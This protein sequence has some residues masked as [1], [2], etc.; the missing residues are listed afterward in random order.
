MQVRAVYAHVWCVRVTAC[1]VCVVCDSACVHLKC[2]DM[3]LHATRGSAWALA[4]MQS[5]TPRPKGWPG[6][7]HDRL[8]RGRQREGGERN[9]IRNIGQWYQAV[10]HACSDACV[11]VSLEGGKLLSRV[12]GVAASGA[13]LGIGTPASCNQLASCSTRS[14]VTLELPVHTLCSNL[15]SN[16]VNSQRPPAR[17]TRPPLGEGLRHLSRERRGRELEQLSIQP[18]Q[19]APPPTRVGRLGAAPQDARVG[20]APRPR[21]RDWASQRRNARCGPCRAASGTHVTAAAAGG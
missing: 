14:T 18:A 5:D 3:D 12:P 13:R 7:R 16:S 6:Q 21:R 20:T 4:R 15:C 9:A 1:S 17:V 19:T 11:C 8:T 10:L 2:L